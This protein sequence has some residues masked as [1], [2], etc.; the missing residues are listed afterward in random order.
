MSLKQGKEPKVV[1]SFKIDP[2]LLQEA[3]DLIYKLRL[4]SYS[5]K[6]EELIRAWVARER[7][8]TY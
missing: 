8:K 7:K 1:S 3:K 5:G 6:V 2:K 4:P